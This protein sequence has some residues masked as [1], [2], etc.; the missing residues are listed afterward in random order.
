LPIGDNL[1]A[2]KYDWALLFL[3]EINAGPRLPI[4]WFLIFETVKYCQE[5]RGTGTRAGEDQQLQT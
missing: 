5:F 2:W 3:K 4:W 1:D